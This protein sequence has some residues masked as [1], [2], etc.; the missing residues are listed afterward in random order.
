MLPQQRR[1]L[2]QEAGTGL[3]V[4]AQ[5]I[6]LC[7]ERKVLAPESE[8][9]EPQVVEPRSGAGCS[10]RIH[11]GPGLTGHV[12]RNHSQ[13]PN[14]LA[15]PTATTVFRWHGN[16]NEPQVFTVQYFHGQARMRRHAEAGF[17]RVAS[18]V[19]ILADLQ[20][21]FGSCGVASP[22]GGLPKYLRRV[23]FTVDE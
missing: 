17:Q 6:H 8:H 13:I 19:P 14:G 21:S 22:L 11:R 12:Y 23:H 16:P 2:C 1:G 7:G 3:P 18:F 20:A 5:E 15:P 10:D 9:L 4:V